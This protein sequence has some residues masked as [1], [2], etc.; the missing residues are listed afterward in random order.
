MNLTNLIIAQLGAGCQLR[1][2]IF[3]RKGTRKIKIAERRAELGMTQKTLAEKIGVSQGAVAQ[4]EAGL[5]GPRRTKWPELA[6]I[7]QCSVA[8]LLELEGEEVE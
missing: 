3:I 4:W 5:T 8:D 6:K 1:N 2:L 7:L